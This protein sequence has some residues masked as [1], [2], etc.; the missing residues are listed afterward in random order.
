MSDKTK[1]IT[2]LLLALQQWLDDGTKLYAAPMPSV[3]DV[4]DHLVA[5]SAAIADQDDR[6]A[7]SCLREALAMLAAAKEES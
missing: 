7:Q 1:D 6:A 4:T 3:P 2:D 5:A